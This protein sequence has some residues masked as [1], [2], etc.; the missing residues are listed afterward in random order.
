MTSIDGGVSA[1]EVA[2]G[3]GDQTGKVMPEETRQKVSNSKKGC[4]GTF[5]GKHHTDES[6]IKM[7][8]SRKGRNGELNG[9]FGKHHT[10]ESRKKMSENNGHTKG[11]MWWNDGTINKRSKEC[12]GEGWS[13]GRYWAKKN[14]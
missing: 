8:E 9:F 11:T 12:P 14:R 2:T 5:K 13:R 6:R 1:D 3:K 4:E 7:S 10:E